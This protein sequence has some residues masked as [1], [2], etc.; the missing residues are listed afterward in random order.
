MTLI[1]KISQDLIEALKA[2]E[3]VR[4]STLRF[5]I[6]A[7]KNAKIAKRADLI[8]EE[9]ISEIAKDAKKHKESIEAYEKAQR[10]ELAQKEKSELVI[11]QSYLPAQM[12]EEEIA[13]IVSDTI[14]E[15]GASEPSDMGKV[16]GAVMAKVKGQADGTIVSNVVKD[17]LSSK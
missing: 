11:L 9:V 5:L 4:V 15:I 1:D 2:H 14:S 10:V 16:M 3:E 12:S 13:K 7:I 17:K 8:D 6:A